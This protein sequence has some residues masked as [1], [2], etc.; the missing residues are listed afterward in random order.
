MYLA[1]QAVHA[2]DEAPQSYIDAYAGTIMDS[3]RRK[4]AGMLSAL[5]EG[6]GNVTA[7]LDAKGMLQRTFIIFTTDNGGPSETC[8]KTGTSNFPHRG[9]KCSLWEG[10]TR[11]TGL[12]HG[13]GLEQI[14]TEFQGFMHAAD[15]LPTL[16]DM[17]GAPVQPGQTLPLDGVS[18]WAQLRKGS[19]SARDSIYYGV[20]DLQVGNHGPA[21]RVNDMKLV[22]GNTGGL[23]GKWPKPAELTEPELQAGYPKPNRTFPMLDNVTYLLF[24]L[25]VDENEHNDIA[26]DHPE[27][28]QDLLG[29]IKDITEDLGCMDC[30]DGSCP[31]PVESHIDVSL[32]DGT[33]IKAWEPWCD[34]ATRIV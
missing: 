17:A 29:Q 20:T 23:P 27:I 16:L 33:V 6:V 14:G 7:A 9:S 5:D 22:V 2:P 30:D 32:P 26:Q 31:D 8:A 13:P 34:R 3:Q 1:Y 11:G 19:G 4:F 28:V 18:Q 15:W 25:S 10:G 12:V 21:L 24:N